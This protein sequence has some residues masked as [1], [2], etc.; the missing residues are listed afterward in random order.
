MG[1]GV[2]SGFVA[3]FEAGM[4]L[5]PGVELILGGVAARVRL[6]LRLIVVRVS[7]GTASSSSGP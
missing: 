5:I 7:R 3:G 1:F 4:G 6:L 2:G